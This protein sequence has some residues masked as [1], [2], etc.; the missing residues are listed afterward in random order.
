MQPLLSSRSAINSNIKM[1]ASWAILEREVGPH[2]WEVSHKPAR[3]HDR[4]PASVQGKL[5]AA[6]EGAEAAELSLKAKHKQAISE[7]SLVGGGPS[8]PEQGNV[9]QSCKSEF[10][11]E[12]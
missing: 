9:S 5:K 7:V 1:K 3:R 6:K 11:E 2:L 12:F 4:S 10:I 8:R